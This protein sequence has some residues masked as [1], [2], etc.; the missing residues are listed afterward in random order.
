[1]STALRL[2]LNAWCGR[3]HK[4]RGFCVACYHRG[5]RTGDLDNAKLRPFE[6]CALKHADVDEVAVQRL[7]AGDVPEHTTI[8]EREAAI[9]QLHAAGLSDGQIGA[10]IGVSADCVRRRRIALGLPANYQHFRTH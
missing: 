8:G 1:M 6:V 2:C 3:P 5:M 9:R 4:A 7:V 10:R